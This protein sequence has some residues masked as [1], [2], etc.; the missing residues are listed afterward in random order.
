MTKLTFK[1]FLV[2]FDSS[3]LALQNQHRNEKQKAK[4][5]SR[6]ANEFKDSMQK[7]R[8]AKSGVT[9]AAGEPVKGDVLQSPSGKQFSVLGRNNVGFRV[10]ELGGNGREG[11]LPHGKKYSPVGKTP[12]GKTI[13][14][15]T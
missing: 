13:F 14:K 15:V 2:E 4:E 7:D 3:D 12:L 1:R 5:Y 8:D 11:N 10:R 9:A 6:D